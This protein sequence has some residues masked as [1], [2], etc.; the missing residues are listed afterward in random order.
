ML[1]SLAQGSSI[2]L[3]TLTG[4]TLAIK[5][6][7]ITWLLLAIKQRSESFQSSKSWYHECVSI[8]SLL[9]EHVWIIDWISDDFWS[10]NSYLWILYIVWA[11]ISTVSWKNRL[12]VVWVESIFGDLGSNSI[13]ITKQANS[14]EI[15]PTWWACTDEWVM[16]CLCYWTIASSPLCKLLYFQIL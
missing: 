14:V 6:S 1:T 13:V 15:W 4:Y 9:S 8:I 5:L 7:R 11:T 2:L 16:I 3:I 10:I 12:Q